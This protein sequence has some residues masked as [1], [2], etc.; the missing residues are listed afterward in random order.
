M[1]NFHTVC[2]VCLAVGIVIPLIGVVLNL[3]DGFVDFLTI[4]F[5]QIDIGGDVS[6]D[7]LPLSINS[8]CLWSLL[9]GG[10][11]LL[12]EN[13]LPI[14]ALILIGLIIGYIAAVALQFMVKKLKHVENFAAEKDEI[15]LSEAIC[16]NAIPKD[17]VGAVSVHVSTGS[18]LSYPAKSFDGNPVAQNKKVKII[19]FNKDYVIVQS[20]TYLEEKYDEDETKKYN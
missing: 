11:G 4:D 12:F 13:N 7:L 8:L 14:W 5:L 16:S 3:F 6:L 2:V 1:E 15:L 18:T 9:F 10:F 17:G 20:E 19:S